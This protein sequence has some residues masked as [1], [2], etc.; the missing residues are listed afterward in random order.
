MKKQ[1]ISIVVFMILSMTSEGQS[2]WDDVSISAQFAAAHHDKRVYFAEE[3]LLREQPEKWGTWQYGLRVE[4][5][6]LEIGHFSI[7]QGLGYALEH[8]TFE[9]LV[10]H[11]FNLQG[12]SCT[13]VLKYSSNYKIHQIQMPIA[14]TYQVFSGLEI[15]LS[16]FPFFALK[17]QMEFKW[18][19]SNEKMYLNFYSLEINPGLD[20]EWNRFRVGVNYRLWQLKRIDRVLFSKHTIP[21]AGDGNPILTEEYEDY[22]PVKLW[23]SVGYRLG[24]SWK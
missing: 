17:K 8:Q 15:N 13:Y 6:W 14:L 12:E 16:V 11:C 21:T 19:E 9:R 4:K 20:Y 1:I 7:S 22:N 24:G 2:F 18:A 5:R 10:D 3:R 23:F